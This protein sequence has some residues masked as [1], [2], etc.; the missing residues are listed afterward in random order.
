VD[1][2]KIRVINSD[3]EDH[4]QAGKLFNDNKCKLPVWFVKS[5]LL[6]SHHPHNLHE[7][8]IIRFLTKFSQHFY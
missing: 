6:I 3:Y 4:L 8:Q 1:V 5:L 2:L 7:I